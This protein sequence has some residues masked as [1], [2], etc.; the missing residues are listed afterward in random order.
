M[1]IILT[2]GNNVIQARASELEALPAAK[3]RR[4]AGDFFDR[5]GVAHDAIGR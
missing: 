5:K 3:R 1:T 2:T 4:Y